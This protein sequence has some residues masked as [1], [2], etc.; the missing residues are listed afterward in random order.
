MASAAKTAAADG[1]EGFLNRL[2]APCLPMIM[3]QPAPE[4]LM[5]PVRSEREFQNIFRRLQLALESSRIGVWEHDPE[6]D[7]I[8]WDL[9]MHALYQTGRTDPLVH[10]EVWT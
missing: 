5:N 7:E 4:T 1:K 6:T 10:A 9:Q 2:P 3:T 8:R